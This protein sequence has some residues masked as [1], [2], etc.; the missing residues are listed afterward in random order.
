MSSF[1]I[2]I[3]FGRCR[4]VARLR[5]YLWLRW[6]RASTA[7]IRTF[8]AASSCVSDW[9][10]AIHT[11]AR[12]VDSVDHFPGARTDEP[13]AMLMMAPPPRATESWRRG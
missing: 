1:R 6:R 12:A 8:F 2:T 7:G 13:M 11:L 10:S 3:S 5:P 9:L 4:P